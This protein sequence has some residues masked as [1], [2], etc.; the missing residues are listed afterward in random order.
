MLP[1]ESVG[2]LMALGTP[3]LCLGGPQGKE[4]VWVGRG[5]EFEELCW[6][7]MLDLGDG[8][9][10]GL[11]RPSPQR[12]GEP[13]LQGRPGLPPPPPPSP[14]SPPRRPSHPVLSV[15]QTLRATE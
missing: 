8:R 3:R 11:L 2:F 1:R 12:G 10:A 4:H 7:D 5:A 6:V 13:G 9:L 15:P 14:C